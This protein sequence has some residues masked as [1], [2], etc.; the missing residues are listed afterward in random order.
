[1]NTK[2]NF[3][4]LESVKQEFINTINSNLRGDTYI[5]LSDFKKNFRDKY[6]NK[7]IGQILNILIKD[8]MIIIKEY[9]N[10]KI[11]TLEK[12][13]KIEKEIIDLI[14]EI[15]AKRSIVDTKCL[16]KYIDKVNDIKLNNEQK[17]A[18]FNALG[19]NICII[20][21]KAGTG[22]TTIVKTILSIYKVINNSGI[23]DIVSFTGKAV[24]RI[25]LEDIK[26]AQ[27]I[28]KF[29]KLSTNK[30]KNKKDIF[31][32]TNLLVIDE[33]AMVD[34]ELFYRLLKS[35][36]NNEN[37][38]IVLLGDINQLNPIGYGNIFKELVKS[39]LIKVINLNKVI[40]QSENSLILKNAENILI[41][42]KNWIKNKKN[43]FEFYDISDKKEIR[44][45]AVNKF[46]ELMEC[47]YDIKDIVILNSQNDGELGVNAINRELVN[48][49][50]NREYRDEKG[51]V[52]LDRVINIKNDYKKNVFNG[53]E[54]IV[55]EINLKNIVVEFNNK[56]IMYT[57]QEAQEMLKLSY[58][59]TIHKMQGSEYK[60]VILLVDEKDKMLNRNLSYVAVTRA[61]E[62]FVGIG[63]REIF[64]RS[65]EKSDNRRMLLNY[66]LKEDNEII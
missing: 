63:S 16:N 24:N 39:K 11:I 47:G 22:K 19:Q 53:E 3:N 52:V 10:K 20:K 4:E 64:L 17:D 55:V 58:A 66:I 61:K 49:I 41:K 35:V 2:E 12:L 34:L 15:K 40:R 38:K 21:G 62:R 33:A 48:E 65:V 43:E 44:K 57:F 30:N 25:S 51:F 28:H 5:K 18:V 6:D 7:Y 54:G 13:Y 29:L 1:M 27:T 50:N 26:G 60:V 14:I 23:I 32:D 36:K 56:T 45:Q 59:N 8:K 46:K 37:I 9:G 31:K 42:K